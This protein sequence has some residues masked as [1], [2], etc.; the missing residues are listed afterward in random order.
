MTNRR[1]FLAG[2]LAAGVA[3]AATW[4]EAGGPAFLAAAARVDGSFVLCGINAQRDILFEIPLPARGHAAAAHPQRPEAVA[5]ARR[6]GTYA[7]VID[8]LTGEPRKALE[9]PAG[10][11]FYGHGT[12]SRDGTWLFTTENDYENGQGRI[13]VW[14]AAHGYIRAA[15]FSSGGIGPHDLKRL[16]GTDTL[17][18]ANGGIDTH[19]ESGRAKLNIPT[20]R[21]N[22]AYVV[23]D[24]VVETAALAQEWH[25][26][27]I[28]HLAVA[29]D[30]RVAVGMQWQGDTDPHALVGLHERGRSM[31]LLTAPDLR[32]MQGYV[33]SVAFTQGE[34]QIIAT[35]PR[36]GL[37]QHYDVGTG[38]LAF[39]TAFADACGAAAAAGGALVTTGQGQLVHV[40]GQATDVRPTP[41]LQWDNHLVSLRNIDHRHS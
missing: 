33:G 2:L 12:F 27:S 40:A 22:L 4:A 14:D 10:R 29:R 20:M 23:D 24:V 18:I 25:K 28:R 36:G 6:P 1:A 30:G 13:G 37:I 3:P 8:C 39:E 19:P 11:H 17:V 21:P 9:A 5:F 26:N 31:T 41:G 15:E 16:P 34:Q 7:M 35:S 32:P 38:A